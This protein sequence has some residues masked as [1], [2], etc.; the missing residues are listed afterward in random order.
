MVYE[1]CSKITAVQLGYGICAISSFVV[2]CGVLRWEPF[3]TRYMIAYLALLLPIIAV[4]LQEIYRKIKS[5]KVIAGLITF[6]FFSMIILDL[7]GGMRQYIILHP[8]RRGPK[9]YFAYCMQD[10]DDYQEICENIEKNGY[11]KIGLMIAE[12]YEYPIWGMLEGGKGR[13][14]RHVN[15]TNKSAKYENMDYI[16]EA[17][18]VTNDLEKTNLLSCHGKEYEVF[19]ETE[20]LRLYTLKE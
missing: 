10:Y 9:S 19:H 16:P 20:C 17:I 2:F 5:K 14:I 15:V 8:V 12:H 11:E 4:S 1:V 6:V 18:I 13:E 7:L 3:V